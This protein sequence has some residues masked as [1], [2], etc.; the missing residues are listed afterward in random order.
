VLSLLQEAL[1]KKQR[2]RSSMIGAD[3]PSTKTETERTKSV[4]RGV[5]TQVVIV[6]RT[7]TTKDNNIMKLLDILFWL[8][9][10]V[11]KSQIDNEPIIDTVEFSIEYYPFSGRY[12]PKHKNF[13]IR[14]DSETGVLELIY[15]RFFDLAIYKKTEAE[16]DKIIDRFKEQQ[17][18]E[19]VIVIKK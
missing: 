8:K 13:Y 12:Y 10:P 4:A 1:M 6:E 9:R 3:Q 16:A 17:L 11:N 7:M 5:V 2:Q 19:T 15:K 18:K 14:E